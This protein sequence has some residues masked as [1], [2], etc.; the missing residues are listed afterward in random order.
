M[1]LLVH[2]KA[3]CLSHKFL[4]EGILVALCYLGKY[5]KFVVVVQYFD[6]YFVDMILIMLFCSF[7]MGK[8]RLF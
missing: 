2:S 3:Y 6:Q 7:K 5:I 8:F 1:S 4:F